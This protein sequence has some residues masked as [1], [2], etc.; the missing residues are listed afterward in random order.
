MN[1]GALVGLGVDFGYLCAELEKLNLHGEFKLVRKS[2]LK[3]GIAA[4]K[5]DV[6]PLKSKPHARSYAGIR[7]ILESSN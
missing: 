2:V 3:N 6:V 5:I 7:Q 4:T 1:L